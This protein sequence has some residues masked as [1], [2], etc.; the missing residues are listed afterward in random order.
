MPVSELQPV[1]DIF[2]GQP[3]AGTALCLSGGGYRA[4]LFH[5]GCLWRLNEAGLL[6]TLKRVSSV[7][8]G[9]IAAGLLGMNWSALGLSSQTPA[10]EAKNFQDLLVAPTRKVA[11]TTIDEGAVFGGIFLPGSISDHVADHYDSLLFH[12]K[13]LQDLPDD[14][15]GP[16]FVINA[17][18]VQ[19]GVLM[20][21]SRKYLRDYRVGQVLKPT[22]PLALAVAASSAFPP[23]L[24]PCEINVAKYGMK[25]EPL[26]TGE[27]LNREPFNTRL[28]LSDGGVYD[29]LGLETA[30]KRYGTLL[31]SDGG[32]H[33]SPEEEPHHDWA[34]HAYRVL[35]L[36]DSQVRALRARQLIQL[37]EQKERKGTYWSI[38]QNA[39]IYGASA[40]LPCP[41]ERSSELALIPTRLKKMD[42]GLQERLINWGY[43][44]CDASLR[45]FCD[46]NLPRPAHFPY[47]AAIV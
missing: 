1:H 44:I 23:I 29:N 47:P 2:G 15:N 26:G 38:R 13:T 30:W 6:G 16:R 27:D 37:L 3:E 18:N 40:V 42:S 33:Y 20:R 25:F 36:I 32:G 9:S 43:A 12:G 24:S 17:T 8:G 7:S 11:S 28:V 31:V 14:A 35:D 34:R 46:D 4:M 10:A 22:L 19:S 45:A 39:S 5:V 41:F 21:F